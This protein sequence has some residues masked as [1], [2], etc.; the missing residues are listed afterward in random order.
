MHWA[1]PSAAAA[2]AAVGEG[3]G[4]GAAGGGARVLGH[5]PDGDGFTFECE[6]SIAED[7]FVFVQTRVGS[8]YRNV[9]VARVDAAAGTMCGV[10]MG[11]YGD[12]AA[13]DCWGRFFARRNAGA[14][15]G[16]AAATAAAAAA[17][18][19]SAPAAAAAGGGDDDASAGAGGG[20]GVD[21]VSRAS[22]AIDAF[23]ECVDAAG[24]A[25]GLDRII[26]AV[27]AVVAS[28]GGGG[29]ALGTL[30]VHAREAAKDWLRRHDAQ[31]TREVASRFG[32]LLKAFKDAGGGGGGPGTPR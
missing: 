14:G 24:A 1:P 11:Y 13:N 5:V 15:G 26:E 31:W 3:A 8:G 2:A 21:A 30:E 29:G 10:W 18:T 6:G 27:G 16:A 9:C 4:S 19:T 20:G 32:R 22:R 25:A 7:A 23:A 12:E 28:A 17:T